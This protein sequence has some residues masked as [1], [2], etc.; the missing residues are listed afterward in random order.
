MHYDRW[1]YQFYSTVDMSTVL[2]C[3]C[4]PNNFFFPQMLKLQTKLGTSLM[5]YRVGRISLELTNN[6][7]LLRSGCKVTS[8]ALE[9]VYE[10]WGL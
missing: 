2:I 7:S 3:M 1:R 9:L 8:C 6:N 5:E 10:C 4:V